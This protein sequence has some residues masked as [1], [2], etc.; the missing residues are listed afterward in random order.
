MGCNTAKTIEPLVTDMAGAIS[1]TC[2][3]RRS[4]DYAKDRGELPF[5]KKGSKVLFRLI[6]LRNWLERDLVDVTDDVARMQGGD[7]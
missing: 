4:L 3:S 1:Y 5:I 7:H 2:M 6:D